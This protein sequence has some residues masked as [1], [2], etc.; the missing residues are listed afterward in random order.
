[1]KLLWMVPFLAM[2]LT[3]LASEQPFFPFC[4]DWHDAKKRNFE[5]QAA[6]LKE[7]G[8]DGVGHLWLDDIDKRL[9]SLDSAGLKLFQ[10]SMQI[11]VASNKP[12]YDAQKFKRALELVKDRHVQFN[13]LMDGMKPSDESADPRVVA[14]LREMSDMALESGSQ[15]L[16]YPH[17]AE[18]ME[19]VQ[20]AIRV[21]EKVDRPNVGV[22]FNLCH[23][24]TSVRIVIT[25]P[26]WR[27]QC[28][29]SGPYPLT[30]PMLTVRIGDD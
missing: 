9:Q 16:L 25:D 19:T 18:W 4:I 30:A 23:W 24:L 13:L 14:M 3:V 26:S 27:R 8:Y 5:Q 21:A 7:L 1:M 2:N 28:R 20:D 12:P 15:L 6:M 17:T 10:I 11:N 22:I 29:V